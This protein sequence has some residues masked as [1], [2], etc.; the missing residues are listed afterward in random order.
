M[1]GRIFGE[2]NGMSGREGRERR[3]NVKH[4][5]GEGEGMR[6]GEWNGWRREVVM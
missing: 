3:K 5:E 6:R 1:R 2:M 4:V